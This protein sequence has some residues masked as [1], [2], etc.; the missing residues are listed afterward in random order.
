MCKWFG[1]H[2]KWCSRIGRQCVSHK[3]INISFEIFVNV[4]QLIQNVNIPFEICV[5]GSV[6]TEN[7]ALAECVLHKNI[8]M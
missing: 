6:D 1:G 4:V 8:N 5:N 3:A 7:C 2:W